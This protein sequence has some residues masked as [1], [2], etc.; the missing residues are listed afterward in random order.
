MRQESYSLVTLSSPFYEKNYSSNIHLKKLLKNSIFGEI[1]IH[2]MSLR[3]IKEK[4][5]S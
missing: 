4:H 3:N 5:R 2:V 1:W